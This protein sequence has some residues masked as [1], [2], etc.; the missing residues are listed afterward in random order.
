VENKFSFVS[1]LLQ[2]KSNVDLPLPTDKTSTK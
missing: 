1:G 2:Q